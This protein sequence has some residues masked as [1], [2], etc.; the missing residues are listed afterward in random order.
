MSKPVKVGY[1]DGKK[2]HLSNPETFFKYRFDN[3]DTMLVRATLY[4]KA[5]EIVENLRIGYLGENGLSHAE[6]IEHFEAL[7]II[8]TKTLTT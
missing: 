1:P 8:R 5:G 4:N 2:Y 6:V 7:E 3:Y